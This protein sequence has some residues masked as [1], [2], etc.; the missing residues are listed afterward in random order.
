MCA[1]GSTRIV[2]GSES[3]DIVLWQD[4]APVTVEVTISTHGRGRLELKLWNVWRGG[5]DVTQAWLGNAAMQ[6]DGD[7]TSGSFRI[8]CSDGDGEPSFDDLVV[9]I[10]V[11]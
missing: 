1:R 3:N 9:A 5:M 10:D 7:P 11:A 2:N 8:Q 4:V 6:I